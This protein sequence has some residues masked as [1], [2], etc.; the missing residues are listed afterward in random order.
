MDDTG[1]RMST[2]ASPHTLR[3][4]A[5]TGSGSDSEAAAEEDRGAKGEVPHV[6][7]SVEVPRDGGGHG[8]S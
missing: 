6:D 5:H 2:K 3:K 1:A 4:A 8:L 7:L